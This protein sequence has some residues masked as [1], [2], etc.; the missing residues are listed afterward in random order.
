MTKATPPGAYTKPG[1]SSGLGRAEFTSDD[2]RPFSEIRRALNDALRMLILHRW[3]FLVPFSLVASGA[4]IASLY[5]PRTY[6]ASTTFE[7]RNDPVMMN[8]PM[9]AGAAGFK[10]YRNTIVRDVTSI[11]TV[12]AVVEKLN[13]VPDLERHED[14]S[15]T[16]PSLRRRDMVARTLANTLTVTTT[17]PSEMID[18]I[19]ITYT[20]PDPDLGARFVDEVKR[21]YISRTMQWIHEFLTSQRDYFARE[22]TLALEEL[23]AAQ[24]SE[25]KLRLTSPYLNPTDPSSIA[26]RESQLELER[27]E[28]LRRKREYVQEHSAA[29]QLLAA[30]EPDAHELVGP[31]LVSQGESEAGGLPFDPAAARLHARLVVL[32]DEIQELRA[33]RGMTEQHPQVAEKIAERRGLVAELRHMTPA[34]DGTEPQEASTVSLANAPA[35][36]DAQPTHRLVRGAPLS[37]ANHADRTQLRI[38]IANAEAKLKDVAISLETTEEA[39]SQLRQ[40]KQEIGSKQEAFGKVLNDVHRGREKYVQ[41]QR[42]VSELEPVITA[43]EGDRLMQFSEGQKARGSRIP[44]S[45]RSTTIVLLALAA[46]LGAGVVFVIL[47]ELVDNVFRSSGQVSRSLGLPLL[48]AID[49]IVTGPDR[50]KAVVKRAVVAPVIVAICIGV[51]G[52]SGSMA[53]LSINRPW[54]Y[55]KIRRVPEAALQ[56]FVDLPAREKG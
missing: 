18:V 45:P 14:G 5:Y 44:V 9:S 29:R 27:N 22:A 38:Q 55:E 36:L 10:Y 33:V 49:E 8:L 11:E 7:R 54:A 16:K 4:F 50:R 25:T 35:D 17:S 37:D 43:I 24:R 15:L 20:G 2:D 53:Y 34:H 6:T 1:A 51:T 31:Q 21:T 19:M 32:D 41:L 26:L 48:E 46:G 47:A 30:L 23:R 3:M 40:A 52:L 56:L 42:K 13:L 28:L 12:G 39:L